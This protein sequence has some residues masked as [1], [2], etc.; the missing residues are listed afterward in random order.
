MD[1]KKIIED[2][3][4]KSEGET[5][6]TKIEKEAS[7]GEEKEVKTQKALITGAKLPAE[8]VEFSDVKQ[9][10]ESPFSYFETNQVNVQ[11]NTGNV[12]YE[13]TDFVLP[14]RDGFDV[15]IARRYDS[16]CANLEDMAP[17]VEDKIETG[18]K[19]NI[20]YTTRYGLGYGWS[21]VLP[22][23]ET[24][25]YL[26]CSY[27]SLPDPM[28]PIIYGLTGYDYI[29]H[30]E[31]G[32]SLK[33]SR[34]EDRF[35]NH[36]LKDIIVITRSD[37]IQHPYAANVTKDY[38]LIIEY[39]NG[40]RDYFKSLYGDNNDRDKIIPMFFTLVA[41]SDKFGNVICY[42]LNDDG[43]MVIVDTWGQEI[44]L[45]KTSDGRLVWKLP[46][47]NV[48][49]A[50][51]IT[52]HIDQAS[53]LRLVA[54]TNT[55]G[56]NTWYDY[57]NPEEYKGSMK[58]CSKSKLWGDPRTEARHYLLLKSITYPNH[59]TTQFIYGKEISIEND[60]GG[61]ITNFVLTMKRDV[62]GDTEYNRREYDYTLDTGVNRTLGEYIQYAEVTNRPDILEKHEFD[63][64]GQLSTKEVKH[65]EILVSRSKYT[66]SNRLI[67]SE[68]NQTFDRNNESVYLEKK[69]FWTYS[70]DRK[71]NVTRIIE[72]YTD[73]PSLNQEINTTYGDYSIV[74]ETIRT[75]G[76]DQIREVNE[77]DADYGLIKCH[78]IYQNGVLKEKTGYDYT[79]TNNRY[80]VT[81]EKRYFLTGSGDLE[82]SNTYAETNYTYSSPSSTH[83][84]YTHNFISKEQTGIIDADGSL[85]APIREEFQYDNWGRLIYKKNSKNQ[86]STTRYDAL[87]RVEA[88]I[89]PMVNGHQ[90]VNET[91]YNDSLN[92][93][94]ETDA[95]HQKRRIQYTPFGQVSQVCLAVSNELSSAD[96]V[97]Q[98]FQYNSW[99][100]LTKVITYD[101]NGI[102][103]G[104]IR[105]TECY[106]YDSFGRV[107]SRA[108][109]Q[110]GYEE[111]YEYNE[112]FTD[113]T[114]GRKYSRE[115]KKVTGDT[116][117]PDI[118]T[119]CYKD[120]KGQVRKELLV[121]ERIFTY[122]YDNAGN[123]IRKIDAGN[124]VERW[125]Y[126]YAG[127]V[128]KTTRTES[129]QDRIT[130]IQYDALGNKRFHWDETG[131]KTEFQY[132]KAGRL[133]QVT[134]PFDQRNR[135]VKYYYDGA[136]NIIWEKKAQK[137]GWQ[138]IQY[139]YDARNRLIDTYQYLS[140][141]NWIRTTCRYDAMNQ[142]ILRRTGDTPSGEGREVTRY[143][144]DRFGNV[145]TMTDSRGCTEY[146]EYD[147]A[148]RLQ[149][150]TDRN[151]DQ[152]VYQHDALEH[153]I[154]E[155]VQKRTPD[156]MVVSDREYVYGKNGKR[157][158]EV[159]REF[160]G[161]KQTVLLE[162]KYRYNRKGQLTRQEDPGNVSKDY[163]YDLYGNRQSFQ[164]TREGNASPD[165]SLYYVYDDLYRLKQIRKSNA[166]GVILAE[167]EYDEKGNRK[168][169]RYPQ[170]GMETN[171]KYNDGNRV[172]SVENKRQGTVISAWEYSYDVAGNI[173]SKINRAG[174]A[175]VTISYQ[176][177]RLG[178]LTEEDY[179]G[180]KRTLYTYDVYSNRIKMMVEGRTKDELVSVTGYEYGLNNRLEKETKKQGKTT[181]TYRYRYDDNGNET[182]RI[183][184]KTVSTPDYP[185]IVKLSGDYQKETPTV[186]EWRHYD[187]FNQ[188]IR[189]NQ[190]NNEITY[191]YRGD[192]LRHSTQVRKL[193]ES[194]GKTN[195]Y[196]W[197]GSDIVA[198]V[199]DSS[200]IKTYL[201][202][203]NLF[204][205]EIDHVVYYYILNEHGDVTQLWSQSGTCKASY[206]YDAFGVERNPDKEDENPFRY[207]GEYFDLS[208]STY[209]LRARDYR[210][211]TG[212]FTREDTLH[213][214][215]NQLPNGQEVP[216]T[217][218]LNLYTYGYN[219]PLSY[220]DPSGH[221]VISTTALV[222]MGL[223]AVGAVIG[224][225]VGNHIANNVNVASQD[226][227]KY[228]TGG[229]VG[230]AVLG[231][232][233]GYVAGPSIATATGIGGMSVTGA[234]ISTVTSGT[235]GATGFEQA[236]Q[237]VQNVTKND[238]TNLY[239]SVGA[240]EYLDIQK[241]GMFNLFKNTLE[242]KQF[243]LNAAETLKFA[244]WDRSSV[245]VIGVQIQTEILNKIGNFTQVDVGIFKSGNVT[246]DRSSLDIF[247][248][249][250]ISIFE[251]Y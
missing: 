123:K 227:W 23:I 65:Q 20:F 136:G 55:A 62:V 32:R 217:L 126:D 170:S 165:V 173:L 220:Q 213:C 27:L 194:Q 106:D 120:Q 84:R 219:N 242:A 200:K 71:A 222:A 154:K 83:S 175:P 174:S 168:T 58:Y 248:K 107:I 114:D 176:Y 134:A 119:E 127:R 184:E 135:I 128:I 177:D 49:K 18:S 22:S 111:T 124:K 225:F 233:A 26:K 94:T 74:T 158:R 137:D 34:S 53:P 193:T 198:D 191:Q 157:I 77:L 160:V 244:N 115:L 214:A 192:G 64:F 102:K 2:F 45:E 97:L 40:N 109:P 153:L 141:G 179:S 230:G 243:G 1:E 150:K 16:G 7:F 240:E 183:W 80:R 30:L 103:E 211:I 101:G 155:T 21:F 159:S 112:I 202:G 54:V 178:R 162:T 237:L 33:I 139:V 226:R 216:D 146:Y 10:P 130:S 93:I 90:A 180:W 28:P 98:D 104:N 116:S 131:K 86:V 43:G 231:A 59:A 151:K 8:E 224:G 195:L 96:V 172:I 210:P 218:S 235:V 208:S 67:T 189:I 13:T 234:G 144:Y 15:T 206:E 143:A 182:F 92:Y 14:G 88:E 152:T 3:I 238:I 52:Y 129:G 117:A 187:G 60:A 24:V 201:R 108:I 73:D 185:G 82:Q 17:F 9:Y 75:K 147:K 122:E 188:L 156:G 140:P 35:V 229:A 51:E 91:N 205:S 138:E 223:A 132:D 190:D 61:R 89:Q 118:V 76:S 87:G 166:A 36:S 239:R 81:S 145:T 69:T 37:T 11:L 56:R 95:N 5:S 181:E 4:D 203:I 164:L 48:G 247:N 70:G 39:K 196:C 38:D 29:L 41:R 169:L 78:K 42:S 72:E 110:A 57:Y 121:G 245:A 100:E 212:R 46:E 31:D 148:G 232:A 249:A 12:Q 250:I 142:V 66:Y 204:A 215:K 105:K 163:T 50:C 6:D 133:V 19:K 228:I 79:D 209:Y 197:D 85:C 149:K 113:L 186:Y 125:E 236:R 246:I 221:F 63:Q 199:T 161:G 68:V 47:S 25:S 241:T 251:K 207:C 44:R 99:G 167:Y 171:Y